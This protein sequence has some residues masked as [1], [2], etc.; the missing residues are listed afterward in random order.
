MRNYLTYLNVE[1]GIIYDFTPHDPEMLQLLHCA[2]SDDK[3]LFPKDDELPENL[4]HIEAASEWTDAE[5]SEVSPPDIL[6]LLVTA[7]GA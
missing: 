5:S 2:S 7:S 1:K 6:S 3:G 4:D